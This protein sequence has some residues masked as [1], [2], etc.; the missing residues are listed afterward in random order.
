VSKRFPVHLVQDT[1]A[2][3][4]SCAPTLGGQR[5]NVIFSKTLGCL[6]LAYRIVEDDPSSQQRRQLQLPAWGNFFGGDG[7]DGTILGGIECEG[8]KTTKSATARLLGRRGRAAL[9]GEKG[10][11]NLFCPEFS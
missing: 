9:E 7:I 2:E 1:R 6:G 10:V 11:E 3:V 8:E 5:A 4:P